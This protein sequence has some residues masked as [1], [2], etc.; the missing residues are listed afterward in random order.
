MPQT[1]IKI[2]VEVGDLVPQMEAI[3]P[4]GTPFQLG[5]IPSGGLL[6]IFLRHIT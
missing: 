4:D 6:V 5:E 2:P 3:N 1:M